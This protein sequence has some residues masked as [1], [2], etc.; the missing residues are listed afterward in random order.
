MI[1]LV[2]Q[3][4]YYCRLPRVKYIYLFFLGVVRAASSQLR[5]LKKRNSRFWLLTPAVRRARRPYTLHHESFSISRA[6]SAC[7]AVAARK[8]SAKMFILGGWVLSIYVYSNF[9][10]IFYHCSTCSFQLK[11]SKI[12]IRRQLQPLWMNNFGKRP[13]SVR[14]EPA[15]CANA[16][17]QSSVLI[18]FL[19]IASSI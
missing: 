8:C 7:D 17:Y 15:E 14:H 12:I 13:L 2:R 10:P 19:D 4:S 18:F 5:V 9:L 16:A 1:S 11:T 3:P 6:A